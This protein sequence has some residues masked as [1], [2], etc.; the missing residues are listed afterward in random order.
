MRK[1]RSTLNSKNHPTLDDPSPLDACGW[2]LGW[3]GEEDEREFAPLALDTRPERVVVDLMIDDHVVIAVVPGSAWDPGLP[4][5]DAVVVLCSEECA[6][7]L[8]DAIA[9]D[10]ARACGEAVPPR[11]P[12][13]EERLA[14]EAILEDHCAWCHAAI[15]D[16]APIETVSAALTGDPGRSTDMIGVR[17]GG[18]RVHALVPPAGFPLPE[19]HHV[20]FVLCSRAC[21]SALARRAA[22]EKI[23]TPIH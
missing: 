18:R 1:T 10:Q 6:S 20:L 7:A 4:G 2:C 19:G 5:A 3:L 21:A 13:D 14:A 16:D 11:T 8:R 12:A 9:N 17:I 15:A 22:A 23:L